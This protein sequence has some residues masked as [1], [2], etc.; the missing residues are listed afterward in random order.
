MLTSSNPLLDP[1]A[2]L[3]NMRL[4]RHAIPRLDRRLFKLLD[5]IKS[6]VK[7]QCANKNENHIE[8]VAV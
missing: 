2:I 8:R 6:Q 4:H 3:L 1:Q 5:G 7:S